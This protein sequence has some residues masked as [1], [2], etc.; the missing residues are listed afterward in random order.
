MQTNNYE[1]GDSHFPAGREHTRSSYCYRPQVDIIETEEELIIQADLPGVSP[2]DIA[3]DYDKGVLAIYGKVHP[4]QSDSTSYMLR[5]Y[6]V[7]DFYRSFEI[8]EKID[9]EQISAKTVDGVLTVTL[10]KA[11]EAKPRKIQVSAN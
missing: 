8:N 1:R 5:E 4:R 10:P 9:P 6:E 2:E 11:K 7:G 3:L